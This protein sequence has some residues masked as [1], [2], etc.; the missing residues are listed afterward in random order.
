MGL[1]SLFCGPKTEGI[2]RWIR[3]YNY[4]RPHQGLEGS[5]PSKVYKLAA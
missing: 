4:Q 1:F 2:D 3:Y 5:I